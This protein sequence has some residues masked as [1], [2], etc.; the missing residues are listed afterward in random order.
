[1]ARH[2]ACFSLPVRLI[3]RAFRL[4]AGSGRTQSMNPILLVL[5]VTAGAFLLYLVMFF[6]LVGKKK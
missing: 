4:G 1:M 3:E 2:P 6:V 5:L